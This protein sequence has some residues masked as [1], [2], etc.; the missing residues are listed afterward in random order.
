MQCPWCKEEINDEASVCPQ[1]QKNTHVETTT[2]SL[3]KVGLAVFIPL[4]I[5][6]LP[7]CTVLFFF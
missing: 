1:C 5:I 4:V 2:E 3:L 7:L 6:A